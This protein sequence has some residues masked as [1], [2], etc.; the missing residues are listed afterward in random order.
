VP[1]RPPT[2]LEFAAPSVSALLSIAVKLS[3]QAAANPAE[4]I[5]APG[6]K[7]PKAMRGGE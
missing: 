4:S 2:E 3:P 6:L 1:P 7:R 5:H